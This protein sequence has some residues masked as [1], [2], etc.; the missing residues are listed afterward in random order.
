VI[1]IRL[2]P[3][4]HRSDIEWHFTLPAQPDHP[5]SRRFVS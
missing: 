1:P 2:T 4:L 5:A 3:L